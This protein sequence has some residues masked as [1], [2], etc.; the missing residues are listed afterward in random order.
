VS[1]SPET[2]MAL[3]VPMKASQQG[4]FSAQFKADFSMFYDQS[5]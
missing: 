3:S 1:S 2:S 4:E 5:M